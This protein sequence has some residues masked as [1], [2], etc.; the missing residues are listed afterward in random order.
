MLTVVTERNTLAKNA[1]MACTGVKSGLTRS[2]TT[3]RDVMERSAESAMPKRRV[4]MG[5]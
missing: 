2:S 4:G 5:D 3:V 1:A